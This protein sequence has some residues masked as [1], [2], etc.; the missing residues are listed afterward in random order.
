MFIDP[1][2]MIPDDNHGGHKGLASGRCRRRW[3][4]CKEVS[5]KVNF[6]RCAQ[7]GSYDLETGRRYGVRVDKKEYLQCLSRACAIY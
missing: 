1:R 5:E 3:F 2:G 6:I 4:G 7:A